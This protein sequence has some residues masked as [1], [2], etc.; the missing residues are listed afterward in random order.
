MSLCS[1]ITMFFNERQ[2]LGISVCNEKRE[3]IA[4]SAVL[5]DKPS[6]RS[7]A[8]HFHVRR[9]NLNAVRDTKRLLLLE[10]M[11]SVATNLNS[12]S[13]VGSRSRQSYSGAVHYP[14]A[15]IAD[16]C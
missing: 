2:Q 7:F 4:E 11:N 15:R 12:L 1:F 16:S 3:S 10:I 13:N 14:V 5:S 8:N 9:C 6:D